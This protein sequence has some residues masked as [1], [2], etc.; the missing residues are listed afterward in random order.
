MCKGIVD[1]RILDLVVIELTGQPL[2]PIDIYLDLKR[3]PGLQL[4]VNEPQVV[5]HEV[6]VK[7]Q[8]PVPNGMNEQA[9]KL[10]REMGAHEVYREAAD[11]ILRRFPISDG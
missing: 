7:M 9:S 10:I 1:L 2:V 5:V 11:S 6:V 3:E 8:A 4:D